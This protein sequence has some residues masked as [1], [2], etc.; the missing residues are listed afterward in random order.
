MKKI[1]ILSFIFVFS[2]ISFSSFLNS[3]NNPF[4]IKLDYNNGFT[5]V[6]YHT[7]RSG[8]NSGVLGDSIDLVK[9]GGQDILFPY[10]RY[11]V[12]ANFFNNHNIIFLYQPLTVNTQTFFKDPVVYDNVTFSGP[13]KIKYGFDFWRVSYLYDF[14]NNDEWLLSAGLSLQVRNASIV[15]ES[16]EGDKLAITQNV[17]P[18]PI[19]K[20]RVK[21]NFDNWYIEMDGDGFYASSAFLNGS[22]FAF[23][24]SIYD[25]VL[26]SGLYLNDYL[27]TYLGFRVIGGSAKGTS[28]YKDSYNQSEENYSENYLTTFNVMI[29]F[30]LK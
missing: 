21:K 29:G 16:N 23:E 10:S 1:F 2:I 22:N 19:I 11:N 5:S 25:V 12:S 13:T 17:G 30:V 18:V 28:Q 8:K 9:T 15:F 26:K 27:E 4:E 3:E 24:G 7:I 14:I 20:A 6:L